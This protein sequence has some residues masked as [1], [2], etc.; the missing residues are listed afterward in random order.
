MRKKMKLLVVFV[1]ALIMTLSVAVLTACDDA[2]LT[3]TPSSVTI[4]DN[5]LTARVEVGGTATGEVTLENDA[6]P[7]AVTAALD[8]NEENDT[9]AIVITGTRP[10]AQGAAAITGAFTVVVTRGGISQ[11]LVVNVNLTTT[12]TAPQ[13]VDRTAL[14][15]AIDAA[16][17]RVQANYTPATWTPFAEALAAANTAYGNAA[18]TQGDIDTALSNL[19]TTMGNLVPVGGPGPVEVTL[20]VVGV[21]A[22]AHVG[23]V[24]TLDITVVPTAANIIV[25]VTRG[26]ENIDIIN[27]AFTV[28]EVGSYTVN[29]TASYG[30]YNADPFNQTIVVS[31]APDQWAGFTRIYTVEDFEREILTGGPLVGNTVLM[32]NI[33]LGARN[34][35]ASS[36]RNF[37]GIFDGNGHAIRNLNITSTGNRGLFNHMWGNSQIRNLTMENIVRVD[38]GHNSGIFASVIRN[39]DGSHHAGGATPRPVITVDNVRI[40]GAATGVVGAFGA[41]AGNFPGADITVTNSYF[42]ITL[43]SKGMGTG[44][45]IGQGGEHASTYVFT[46]VFARMTIPV[47]ITTAQRG[48]QGIGVLVGRATAAGTTI[49]TNNVIVETNHH[50]PTVWNPHGTPPAGYQNNNFVVR[51]GNLPVTNNNLIHVGNARFDYW[52]STLNDVVDETNWSEVTNAQINAF[53]GTNQ[54]FRFEVTERVFEIFVNGEW[55]TITAPIPLHAVSWSVV[56]PQT[57][58]AVVFAEVAG[59]NRPSGFE[60][61]QGSTIAFDVEFN[62]TLYRVELFQGTTLLHTFTQSEVPWNFVV[63]GPATLEFRV[64]ALAGL[65]TLTVTATPNELTLY[66]GTEVELNIVSDGTV[67]ITVTRG[68]TNITVQ[69]NKFT[70]TE[71]GTYNISVVATNAAGTT[72][73]AR[74]ITA[75]LAPAQPTLIAT[76][77][78]FIA[79]LTGTGAINNEHFIITAD[80]D[81]AG[82]TLGGTRAFNN[83]ILDGGGYSLLNLTLD[84]QSRGILGQINNAAGQTSIIRNLNIVNMQRTNAGPQS[85]VLAVAIGANSTVTVDNV[86]ASVNVTGNGQNF[87]FIGGN[88]SAAGVRIEILNSH[89]DLTY[90]VGVHSTGAIIGNAH[91]GNAGT[92]FVFENVFVRYTNTSTGGHGG[93]GVLVGAMHGGGNLEA[94]DVVL[95]T[96]FTNPDGTQTI[97]NGGGNITLDNVLHVG[98]AVGV[99]FNA[100]HHANWI[101][102]FAQAGD[103]PTNAVAEF[104]ATADNDY[105]RVQGGAFSIFVNDTWR[106]IANAP[107]LWTVVFEFEDGV[108]IDSQT[109]DVTVAPVFP[110]DPDDT[111]THYF[112]HWALY[113]YLNY[114]VEASDVFEYALDGATITVVAVF[115]EKHTITFVRNYG[116]AEPTV[117]RARTGADIVSLVPDW[118]RVA[119]GY[120]FAGW[121]TTPAT[122]GTEATAASWQ[123]IQGNATWHARWD[124]ITFYYSVWLYDWVYCDIAGEYIRVALRDPHNAFMGQEEGVAITIDWTPSNTANGY[125]L[126]WSPIPGGTVSTQGQINTAMELLENGES[127]NLYAV[128][129][130][131][132]EVIFN[133]NAANAGTITPVQGATILVRSG[134]SLSVAADM[135]NP[136]DIPSFVTTP[137]FLGWFDAPVNGDQVQLA[138][139]INITATKTL[140]AQYGD[141]DPFEGWTRI[142][143]AA[144]FTSNLRVGGDINDGH[145]VLTA[146]IDMTGVSLG[147]A[148][149]FVRSILDGN[150]H[151]VTGL[152]IPSGNGLF[153]TIG[154]VTA[155]PS[156]VRNINFINSTQVRGNSGFIGRE[157]RNGETVVVSN[158][159]I[160]VSTT[161][162]TQ[163]HGGIIGQFNTANI[164]VSNS[165]ITIVH[166]Q[167]GNMLGGIYGQTWGAAAASS[168]NLTNVV[169]S[170]TVNGASNQNNGVVGG[171]TNNP[172]PFNFTNVVLMSSFTPL[173]ANN[174]VFTNNFALSDTSSNI[175][176]VGNGGGTVPA[177]VANRANWDVPTIE[178]D[179]DAFQEDVPAFRVHEDIFQIHVNGVWRDIREL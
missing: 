13:E 108:E 84:G 8:V 60:F 9:V 56:N 81:F 85:A 80:L 163:T 178:D 130:T 102:A 24:I 16:E 142:G 50:T 162:D 91:S 15:T 86:F 48:Y 123:N 17:L 42:C 129:G 35:D 71:V 36:A 126:G 94:T 159:V 28:T 117:I 114:P 2:T 109:L 153:N 63:A 176:H 40:V 5:A 168:I 53:I 127:M 147:A 128:W 55:R 38:A 62:D 134:G 77:A 144:E 14:R 20:T 158:V 152:H 59:I 172:V 65:P 171:N 118:D 10:T 116:A 44:A 146:D 61:E 166:A 156:I 30:T 98:N 69:D 83:S 29:V 26:T 141:Y 27:N 155:T 169:V 95:Y 58:G 67:E 111:A 115:N 54:I 64:V 160:D 68:T 113:G 45:V 125:F 43:D 6:L 7:G 32:N 164:Y 1:V 3:L 137:A 87:G 88:F 150:G 131:W 175:I 100:I 57:S 74:T 11:D 170:L 93:A 173:N 97:R 110:T 106:V 136:T 101:S 167:G 34:W 121:W 4:S 46:N 145:F 51:D 120:N 22:T 52:Y 133:P 12:W 21:P 76:A 31:E 96:R 148:S 161:G 89:F 66:T 47:E 23:D 37:S 25:T 82:L 99:R 107:I 124:E 105:F 79:E 119:D 39:A 90:A 92:F 75:V 157:A 177:I 154:G 19:N 122:A 138:E 78:E 139:L 104:N 49:T 165:F 179:V 33:D 72:T 73:W 103:P 132:I 112:S 174:R 149:H 41:I 143:T 140:Y 70:I 151:T 18:A 135:W